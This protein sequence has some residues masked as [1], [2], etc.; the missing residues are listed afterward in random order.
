MKIICKK[1]NNY[2]LKSLLKEY[3]HLDIVIVE[4]GLEYEGLCYYFKMNHLDQLIE[5][6]NKLDSQGE[7][8]IGYKDEKIMK[9]DIHHIIYIEGFSKEAYVYTYNDEYKIKEKLYEL[10]ERLKQ[11][12]FIRI[13]KSII[14]NIH[15]IKYIIPE[16]YNRYSIYMNNGLVLVLSRSYMKAFK[17]YLRIR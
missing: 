13:N 15:E 11:F 1:E 12:G 4:K 16:I 3:Q 5:Y 2:Q 7:W 6:L 17:E 8:I 14:I 10:E 9:I